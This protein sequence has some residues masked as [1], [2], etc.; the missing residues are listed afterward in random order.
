LVGIFLADETLIGR[1]DWLLF[2]QQHD[3]SGKDA[4]T[5]L[6]DDFST[7]RRYPRH[8]F[9]SDR[10]DFGLLYV[11][12]TSAFLTS[13]STVLCGLKTGI[14]VV[15]LT[16][17]AFL[18]ATVRNPDA[19]S[20]PFPLMQHQ[21]AATS[22]G[23]RTRRE[24]QTD[25]H[26][27]VSVTEGPVVSTLAFGLGPDGRTT[28]SLMVEKHR[29]KSRRQN[30]TTP[31]VEVVTTLSV[32]PRHE[33]VAR[34]SLHRD[35]FSS[36]G[37]KVGSHSGGFDNE[38]CEV[39]TDDGLRQEHSLTSSR[40]DSPSASFVPLRSAASVRCSSLHSNGG[41]KDEG[42]LTL[43][44][45]AATGVRP[46]FPST[47]NEH[48]LLQ[49]GFNGLEVMLHR[50]LPLDDEKGL[51]EPLVDNSKVE[52]RHL[53]AFGDR[54]NRRRGSSKKKE[55]EKDTSVEHLV[56]TRLAALAYLNP[57]V[58]QVAGASNTVPFLSPSSTGREQ[59]SF[60]IKKEAEE[61]LPPEIHLLS[62]QWWP[63]QTI[64]ATAPPVENQEEGEEEKLRKPPSSRN[65][66]AAILPEQ[67]STLEA[68]T[69][70]HFPNVAASFASVHHPRA[71]KSLFLRLQHLGEGHTKE[72]GR[73]QQVSPS[74][75]DIGN[76][77]RSPAG[78]VVCSVIQTSLDFT[79]VEPSAELG[80][81]TIELWPGDL[82][83]V[84]ISLG[85]PVKDEGSPRC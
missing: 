67:V 22:A 2:P 39:S 4:T 43:V 75:V 37:S 64:A 70:V 49:A 9:N 42:F 56:A 24:V 40:W 32:A 55:N 29:W 35:R 30:P 57:V 80:G 45:L 76:L 60:F 74:R 14:S 46:T 18:V 69:G 72:N 1:F 78:H 77:F 27:S 7:T 41:Q 62:V 58:K 13:T 48:N 38:F 8:N 66:S 5:E 82:A 6:G 15:P 19:Q 61:T 50:S 34:F 65:G 21:A 53:V 28:Q 12:M 16:S 11:A 26:I 25:Q 23:L 17:V 51:Q 44:P 10:A 3:N 54:R 85:V 36:D 31:A 73:C 20:R 81:N 59:H 84:V 47:P 33:V 52:L 71:T 68:H 79:S 83:A 63:T